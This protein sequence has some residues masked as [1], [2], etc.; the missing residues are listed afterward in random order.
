MSTAILFLIFNR[1]DTTERVFEAIRR[2][3]PSR[4][5]VAADGPRPDRPQEAD[6]CSQAR[7]VAAA[8]DWPCEVQTLHRR[9][10]LGCR[11]AVS[12]AIDWFFEHEPEGIILEDDCLPDPTFF[13]FCAELLAR[14]RDDRRIMCITGDNFQE[15]LSGHPFSYYFSIY[16][17]VWGWATWRRAWALYDRDFAHLLEFERLRVLDSLSQLPG[18][19]D[20]WTYAF[21]SAANGQID[22][23]DFGWIFTCWANNGLTCTPIRNLVTNL[24]FRSDATHTSDPT[25]GAANL[26]TV[27]LEFP[28]Q[29]PRVIA[30]HRIMDAHV[31][32]HHFCINEVAA[33]NL[34]KRLMLALKRT[35]RRLAIPLERK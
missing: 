26:K 14:F 9:Q 15:H 21:N 16:P 13:A 18:F 8:V 3:R 17:H 32:K 25:S 20:H 33:S 7:S 22:T 23:W 35:K 11:K 24:G 2:S 6:L 19:T 28:L 5:Y 10:N 4:L 12:E 34:S 27:P 30:P 1:P 31:S 29:H